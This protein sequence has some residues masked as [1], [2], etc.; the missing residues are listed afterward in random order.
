MIR[1][2]DP[3]VNRP[4]RR[5]E[6]G[7]KEITVEFEVEENI[8]KSA[9]DELCMKKAIEAVEKDDKTKFV[10][11]MPMPKN[12]AN[13]KYFQQ[14]R[15][16]EKI[17]KETFE[18]VKDKKDDLADDKIRLASNQVKVENKQ[19]EM[20][21]IK[22]SII[23][24]PEK[25]HESAINDI[26]G[27]QR[28]WSNWVIPTFNPVKAS[29]FNPQMNS[30]PLIAGLPQ[31]PQE[32]TNEL[33]KVNPNFDEIRAY[34]N[35]VGRGFRDPEFPDAVSSILGF[36]ASK[37]EV[38]TRPNLLSNTWLRPNKIFGDN[39]FY[40]YDKTIEPSDIIQGE[41]GDCY[42]L[43]ALASLAQI[44]DRIERIIRFRKLSS[45]GVYCFS[46][47][48]QGIWEDVIIDDRIPCIQSS[49]PRPIFCQTKSREIWG[50]LL[51]KAWAKV[52]GGYL[53]VESGR[54]EESFRALSGAP[55]SLEMIVDEY[56]KEEQWIELLDS[57]RRGY[58]LGC[59]SRDFRDRY[60]DQKGVDPKT[61]LVASHG[62][63]ILGV[64]ELVKTGA[65]YRRLKSDENPSS[66]NIRLIKI[67][68][69]WSTVEW[70]GDW[71]DGSPLWTSELKAEINFNNKDD[72][73][74]YMNTRDFQ[75][76]FS[77]FVVCKYIDS[78][79][80]SGNKF[81]GHASD[82]TVFRFEIPK[83]GRWFFNLSQ[84]SK[85]F[86]RD[87]DEYTYSTL[88]MLISRIK[89]DGSLEEVGCCHSME[90]E[91]HIE[92]KCGPG[93]YVAYICTPWRRKVN[94]FGFSL[95]GPS[96]V[97]R[98]IPVREEGNLKDFFIKFM[99]ERAQKHVST[100]WKT[101]ES[102]GM[103]E[104]GYTSEV[105][106]TGLGF[107]MFENSSKDTQ[108][109]AIISFERPEDTVFYPAVVDDKIEL[110]VMPGKKKI[111]A[112][113][114]TNPESSFSYSQ[115]VS[116][117]SN[118]A[119]HSKMIKEDGER[120]VRLKDGHDVG[121]SLYKLKYS[122]GFGYLYENLSKV[123]QLEEVVE[124]NLENCKL[125][126]EINQLHIKLKPGKSRL[127]MI[128]A[129]DKSR[130]FKAEVESCEYELVR[131]DNFANHANSMNVF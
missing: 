70:K 91:Q 26:K 51:E 73:T 121:V 3:F 19:K 37:P 29:A 126:A 67:R 111:I 32:T 88:T 54:L 98:V 124:F 101:F 56:M 93:T 21:K 60:I 2:R 12:P 47:C 107:V 42:F 28:K 106:N 13:N 85:R 7:G 87:S 109:T 71:G 116:F 102:I 110:I 77:S 25:P 89:S 127:V 108:V 94:E 18:M 33:D 45:T 103:P 104:I 64:Y 125:V 62:Y 59:S 100:N 31:N 78:Y 52:H 114:M 120:V 61:G 81:T 130:K 9:L 24:E 115:T 39:N 72:G 44:R 46:L 75:R 128:T 84:V 99:F 41:L 80:S 92:A 83:G 20:E 82:P 105:S 8:R 122:T 10:V 16:V 112:F 11:K 58:V 34:Q 69:P 55:V 95:Y 23:N 119:K 118:I 86:F 14:H 97:E 43:S 49:V 5:L 1:S 38:Q 15:K 129:I 123:Y 17:G 79:F 117:E 48:L 36:H 74:F 90:D 6:K 57:R 40:L 27:D 66:K 53:N 76:H 30:I 65:N 113:R 35:S 63:S 131:T 4:N 96:K 68:N 50:I 22:K